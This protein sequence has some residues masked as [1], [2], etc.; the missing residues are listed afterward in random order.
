MEDVVTGFGL[1]NEIFLD[2]DFDI[3]RNFTQNG[4]DIV[5]SVLGDEIAI[6]SGDRFDSD[7]WNDGFW[8]DEPNTY[9]DSHTY[10]G[11]S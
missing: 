10:H 9:L 4:F 7:K 1:L 2:C 11:A 6:Y 5:R 3:V 8:I